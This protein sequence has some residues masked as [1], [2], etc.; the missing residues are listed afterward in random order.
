MEREKKES[1]KRVNPG[2]VKEPRY[3]G[4]T[5]SIF[6]H[7]FQCYDVYVYVYELIIIQ[8]SLLFM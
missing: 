5:V 7:I 3:F 6:Y 4:A 1:K 8:L 2:R